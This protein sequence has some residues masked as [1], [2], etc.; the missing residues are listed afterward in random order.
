MPKEVL[1]MGV[2]DRYNEKKKKKDTEEEKSTKSG[3]LDRYEKN[4]YYQTLDTTGVDEN[5]VNAFI[6]DANTFF[7]GIGGTDS[8]ISFN[9]ARSTVEDL[10]TRY[11]TVRAWLYK[12]KDKLGEKNYASYSD[13]FNSFGSGLDSIKNYY[14]QWE[15]EEDYNAW[16][17]DYKAKQA[18]LNSEDFEEYSQI[19]ANIKNPTYA[20]AD[21]GF[22]IGNWR[23]FGKADEIGNIVTFSRENIE[24]IKKSIALSNNSADIGNTLGDYRYQFMDDNEVA[25][26]NYYLG[27]GDKEKA[28]EFLKSLDDTLNQRHAGKIVENIDDTFLE[29][30]FSAAA[31]LDSAVTGTRDII[32]MIQGTEGGPTTTT[33]YA[34]S[35]MQANNEGVFKVV[36]DLAYTT[37]NMLPSIL[38][39]SLTGGV[40]GA[41]TLGT[42]AMGNAYAEMR[43]LGYNK[44]QARGYAVL[45]GAS[46]A[47]LQY[48]LGGISKLGGKVSGNAIANLV[49][50]VDNAIAR[51][52]IQIGGNMLAEGTEEALQSVLEP[53]FKALATGETFEGVEW[54]EVLYSAM[55]GALSAGILEGVPTIAGTAVESHQAKDVYGAD[56]QTL[57]NEAL[58]VDP[59]NAFAQ[60]KKAQLDGGKEVSGYQLNRLAKETSDA[61]YGQD[62]TKMKAAAEARL[63]E[64]GETENVSALADV[65][66][67]QAVGETLN[68]IESARFK[69]S[70]HGLRV[71]NEISPENIQSG[72]YSSAWAE[73]I[74]TSFV[75]AQEYNKR[76]DEPA[77]SKVFYAQKKTPIAVTEPPEED[78]GAKQKLQVSEDG[79]TINLS[80]NEEVTVKEIASVEDG[81]V[82]L[83]LE[84]G[85]T[86]NAEDLSFSTAE[87]AQ[88]YE[89][90][91]R[92]DATPQVANE[93]LATFKPT[94]SQTANVF[95]TD[96]PLAYMYGKIGYEAGLN[97]IKLTDQQKRLA[98]NYGRMDAVAK[99][100]A[101]EKAKIASVG[102]NNSKKDSQKA[103]KKGKII[104]ENG[105]TYNEE[106]AT[107]IQKASMAGIKAIA[108]MSS[109]EVHVYE[110]IVE[111]GK[112][113]AIVNGKKRLAPNG[114][115]QNGNQI[116]I[117]IN[118]G[119][120]G[121]GVILYTLSH[122]VGHYI[123]EHNP[124]DFKVIGDFLMENYGEKGVNVDGLIEKQKEKLIAGYKTDGK[125][126]PSESKL[127]DAA[128]EELVA[129]AMSEMLADENAY[130]KLAELKKQNR[131]A[132]Q[133]LG[134]AIKA[135]LDKLKSVLGV[136]KDYAPEATEADHVRGFDK[137]TFERLQD[138][139][140]KAFVKADENYQ[141][142]VA[143]IDIE[144]QSVSP[145]LSERTWTE[146][147]Y[148]T[149][150]EETA[151]KISTALGVD[152]K[153]AYKYIDDINGVARLIADDRARLDYEPNLDEHATVLKPNS[154]YKYTVDMSTL[155][156]KRL[157]FTGTFDAIQKALPNMVFDSED[158]VSLR[159]MMQKRGY[160]VA[161]GICY[162]ESTRREIGR[163]T[164][165]F[166][167]RYKEA[168]KTG[169]PI[170]R[171]NSGGKEVV[172]KSA[173]KT[174]SADPNYT[175]N[176]G[177][178]N[179]TDID[180]VKRD[181]REVYDAYLAFMNARGQ[182]KPKLLET[183]A[184]YKGE[185]L[186]HFKAK[187]AVESRNNA[188]GLRL[189]SFSDFEVPHMI[190]MMQ[191]V[192]DM[193]RVG[194]KSQA[195][196]KV[197]AF[198]EVFGDTGVKINL[199]LIAK[200]DGLD[201]NGNLV[202]DD[203]EGINH[204][205]AFKLREKYSKN[206]GT[207]LVGK[208]DAHIIKAMA[209]PRIDYIIPFHKSSW[210]ESLYDAL[211]L[212]G[213][214]D[215][216]DF[217]NEKPIDKN[218][219]ISNFDPSEYWDF[220]KTG[221]ENAQ[222]Y[223]AKCR[224]DGRIPKFS[225]FQGYPGYWKLLIDFKMYDNN[226]VGS[227]QEVVKPV[228]NTEASERILNDYK[229]GHKSFPVAKDVV[230]DF[231]KEHEGNE[232][233]YSDRDFASQVDDVLSGSDTNNSHL[234]LM[235]TPTLLQKAGLPNLPV[236]MTAKHLKTITSASGSGKANYHGLDIEV[237]KK[238]PEYISDPI[239]IADSFTREDSIVIIT[240]AVDAENKPV[241]AAILLNG[242][243][244]L[245]GKHINA[246]IMTSAYGK[247]N[248]QTFLN[249]IVDSES[250][251]YWNEKKS[252]DM[253]VSL[254]LQLP[255]AM[256]SLDSGVI[257]HQ[258]KAFVNTSSEKTSYQERDSDNVSNR[259][260]L[261]NALESAVQNDVE[262][263]KLKEYK[264][265]IALIE[266]EQQKLSEIRAKIKELSFAKGPRDTETIKKLQ[267]E[268]NQAANRIN[269]YDRQL[270]NLEATTALKGVLEREK[271]MAR[272][273]A[274]KRGKEAL[275][276]YRER[277]AKTQR[278]LITRYQESRQK[279]T[280]NR[281][282]T[283]MR[284]KIKDVV[285][286][287]NQYLL[288]GTKDKHVP[289]ELQKAVAEALDAVNMDTVG[290]DERIAK[291]QA[292][293]MKAKTPEAIQ[294]IAK[295]IEHIAE[296]GGNME[297]KLSRLKTAYDG[298]INSDD[299]LIANSHDDVISSSIDKVIEVVGNTPLRDMSL[300]QLEA[301]H[302]MYRMVLASI[303]NANKAFKEANGEKISTIA[304][305]VIAELDEQ[306][307][308]PK[309]IKGLNKLSEFDWNN[310]KPVYAF[311]RIGSANFTK[312][313][314]TVRAGEDVWA[315]DVSEAK[316]F[317]EEQYKKH[318]Y[319]S[320]DFE[321]K[322]DFVSSTGLKFTL[323]LDQIMSLYA[324]SKRG[325]QAKDHL[326]YGGFQ[327][328]G[329][330]ETKEK[331]GK[332]VSVTYQLKDTAAYK[333]SDELLG[334]IIGVLDTV[335]GAKNFVDEMQDYLS[336]TM[337]EKGNEVSLA[338]YQVKLF[339]EKNYFPLRV[340]HDFLARAREQ[341]QGEVKIKNSGFTK[342]TKPNAKNPIV[343]SSFMDVWANHVNEMSMYHAF[344]LPLEDFYR[345]YNYSTP[346]DE[347]LDTASVV[348]YL[349]GAHRD[350]AV[351]Y[352][353]QLLKD[354]N[355][356]AR[357]DST[358]DIISKLTGL[359]KKSAVFASASVVVQQ[360]SAIARAAALVDSKYFVGKPTKGK[361]K[362]K[363]AEVKKY[364]PVAIIKEMGYF[365]TGMGQ[366][367]VEWLKGEKTL[368]D[369]IDDIA[370]KAPALADE[371]SWC[372]IWDAVKRETLQTRPELKFNSEEFLKAVGERFTEVVT[373]T[374]VY[375]SVLA[376]SANMRSKD[377]GMK[378]AT[379]FLGEP[380]T[381]LNML[382]SALIQGKRGNK[383]Y[384]RKAVGS[385]VASMI[386]NSILVSI[387]YAGRDDDEDKT[388]AEKY[389]STL[390]E[391][392]LDSLNPLTLIPFV[393]DIVSIAQGYDVERSDMAVI[394]DLISAWN[395][396]DSD[397]RSAYRKVEDFGGAIASI[398]GLPVKNIMRDARGMYNTINSFVNGEKTT[399][400]GIKVA[401]KEAITGKDKSDGQQ[402]Y[403]AMMN[404]DK[405][406]VERVK[407]RFKDQNAVNSAIRK[408]LR[409][410]DSRI[411]E[412]A[413]ARYNGDTAEY[414][415]IAKEIIGEGIFSQDDVV[416][417]INSEISALKKGEGTTD[418]SPSNK[419]GSIYEVSDYYSAIVG[420][421]QASAN[422]VKE[423][424][425]KTDVA[426]G[427]DREEAEADF[428]SKFASYLREQ[429]EVGGLSEYEARNMLSTYGGK[430]AEEAASKVQYWKFK[431]EYPDYDL[432]EEAVT[433]YYSDVEPS[434]ISVDVYYDYSKKRSKCKG[435]DLN[436]D[437][438]TDS[439]SVKTEVL[440]V[441]DSL[442]IS[443]RQKDVLYYLNGWSASTIWE[444]PWH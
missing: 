91:A 121:E 405:A 152:L 437:G 308:S 441:I 116:Y 11:D 349:R 307:K 186:K 236:L 89:M 100:K 418:S 326:K 348:S 284:H 159:E 31:G 10:G 147:E 255:N 168:Q 179:T 90:V 277:V 144:T 172:L 380:T 157:L 104:Y 376:R 392:L 409:D 397:N 365:D 48:A 62:V 422:V 398:F 27:K 239:I 220:S 254:G 38:V 96:V 214:A 293:M 2:M 316:T 80:T 72:M 109:L 319:D 290:A 123:R 286:E 107:D 210:K 184:E 330:T 188:G 111:N 434:G 162:V 13:T 26:Y 5:Y 248:F 64:L 78:K 12:N 19:G 58:Q 3:V 289:I 67:K 357:V 36:N 77:A 191:V 211:G 42:S 379:A 424:L 324:F 396:L 321:K 194:L 373:K 370:S 258:A 269:T 175:P 103:A 401:V 110:S 270:L 238:L 158:I 231:V 206:V 240:E 208:T 221:D 381:S 283:A 413:E 366:S 333:I 393:K 403:D 155:C 41:L 421:D 69:N 16:Y 288:K 385:V 341:A 271:E 20:E 227:P 153:T 406:Q 22:A 423:D 372:V 92:M 148:V 249:R 161:C 132:W 85:S 56:A 285:N 9:D 119:N 394:S 47:A 295:K 342:E 222:I 282:R 115:Y 367:T 323:T 160:E 344:T 435:T 360:P 309:V 242:A 274:E 264:G 1:L 114:Y 51:T 68:P 15:T 24:D 345:V 140:I 362:E 177:E 122:E 164:Q 241:I 243:G 180:I 375:D 156:A 337:G 34:Q 382:E 181:H 400:E 386:L 76:L 404:G 292:E 101:S 127:L 427:K 368:R 325:Q 439:G 415:R 417:A 261:A 232:V 193:S 17:D 251:I 442:P 166:I 83:R 263:N 25:I 262:R 124:E 310:L 419:V 265:K 410:N 431:M 312:V 429:Y 174:F 216:T 169:K 384:A 383:R 278:E 390:T 327:F 120:H 347:K 212:T 105:F 82:S 273:K 137:A 346:N 318:N 355:G 257:I 268:A 228:F 176:L 294:A 237:V 338:L 32:S 128:Y 305:G 217:Q 339:K 314:N 195:Y 407:G 18:I 391:E 167:D 371:Y 61:M 425:I 420:R 246:N 219:K 387:V 54:D 14:S 108:E 215:Y 59:N 97:N 260:L 88:M 444:A 53:C 136:Y 267:F 79:K 28:D 84:D 173:G 361:H 223:L 178:L 275:E 279:A 45:V 291:L 192:M 329:V 245:D 235:E 276:K 322:Y 328:D 426:N 331:K 149:E 74:G 363:W 63:T 151:K 352:I 266:A 443:S 143:N 250:L 229:G 199:S 287:L 297:A 378:M 204:E 40:G 296:M 4:K 320:F 185:I 7:K 440:R 129:D 433:K 125:A 70:K 438:K 218:R 432:S 303:R 60:R 336:A 225:Q 226:G 351:K 163:I 247:D 436:G 141:S 112:R 102:T 252:Q 230:E 165:E 313:F 402:L 189:Q 8:T 253:S 150:R 39:G 356:G 46:E 131:N 272:K 302:D 353:D 205:E 71:S 145:M 23:P 369:K 81:K 399:G 50:K 280:E 395:N 139:Y 113:Y 57:V 388:Y 343:L 126:I 335:D 52:A 98:Y 414:M 213:Y 190:D 374:Q 138:M 359:F 430:S 73:R 197:P 234:K 183:R 117:D 304:N 35:Q 142:N 201:A 306:Q 311:E 412:A 300:Y 315:T 154:E 364:A 37:G 198:A 29:P 350:G 33:R 118:A 340:S 377:T 66:V 301:V 317:L 130:V 93:I 224:E 133:K 21:G 233:R 65:V 202:F 170:T 87:E 187:S 207:I 135:I 408:A 55:L 389:V 203:V 259:T 134:D 171:I 99:V 43:N 49:S 358:A 106:Q 95:A 44:D 94:D 200:G 182:A 30:L 416:A 86:V 281:N 411:K 354:L 6:S 146:S 75:N 209:D 334:E 428:N 244:R 332:V 196:T 298:I 299:P 256:T